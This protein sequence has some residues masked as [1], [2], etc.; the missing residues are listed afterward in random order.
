MVAPKTSPPARRPTA[1][2]AEEKREVA[3]MLLFEE[4]DV[5]E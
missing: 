3:L 5:L 1:T 4:E 2:K